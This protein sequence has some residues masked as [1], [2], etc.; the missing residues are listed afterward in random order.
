MTLDEPIRGPGLAFNNLG[1]ILRLEMNMGGYSL[2][3]PIAPCWG[4]LA[5]G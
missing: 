4:E 1:E 3:L 5:S 2:S